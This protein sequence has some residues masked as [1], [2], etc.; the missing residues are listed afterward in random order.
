MKSRSLFWTF[1]G[2]FL[3][4]VALATAAQ[5]AIGLGVLRPLQQNS[6]KAQAA[7]ALY[8]AAG[9]IAELSDEDGREIMRA[10]H[11]NRVPGNSLL[12][13]MDNW[14]YSLYHPFRYRFTD[15]K[16]RR[17]LVPQREVLQMEC[18]S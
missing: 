16:W 6:L 7:S 2:V 15:G 1:A 4:V 5:V 14:I 18:G 8:R 12:L 13:G 9:Q 11:E 17:E 3:L 10:L